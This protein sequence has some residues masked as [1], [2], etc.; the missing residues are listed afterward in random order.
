[1]CS[2]DSFFFG[3]FGDGDDSDDNIK[4]LHILRSC[5]FIS[6]IY[7]YLTE[8]IPLHTC[9]RHNWTYILPSYLIFKFDLNQGCNIFYLPEYVFNS[10]FLSHIC[11]DCTHYGI[12]YCTHIEGTLSVQVGVKMAAMRP[13]H[14]AKNH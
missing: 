6:Y 12:Q 5:F 3:L 14:V 11:H 9:L 4:V 1:L 2:T 10:G 7:L 8:A 13:K